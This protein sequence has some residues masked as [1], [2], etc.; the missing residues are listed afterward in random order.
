MPLALQMANG[1]EP[2]TPETLKEHVQRILNSPQLA[3]AETQ[4]RLLEYLWQHRAENLNEYAIATDALGRK[5]DFD[6]TVDASVRVHISRLRRKLKD[7]YL[8]TGESEVLVIPTG[9]H[10][11]VV[12]EVPVTVTADPIT[13]PQ[14]LG[15]L[16]APPS[17]LLLSSLVVLS[18]VCFLVAGFLGWFAG[19]RTLALS[20]PRP[21]A[22]WS[23]FLNYNSAPIKIILPTPVFFQFANDKDIRIRSTRVNDFHDASIDPVFG[24]LTRDLGTPALDQHYTVTADTLAA[25]GVARYLD[26]VGAR[27]RVSFDVMRDSDML[28]LEQSNVIALGTYQTLHPLHEYLEAMNFSLNHDEE[29]ALNAKPQSGEQKSYPVIPQSKEREVRPSIIAL[30]PGR[31][32]GLRVLLIESRETAAQ[33]SL[34]SSNA[35]AN[36]V[37]TM[38][39]SHGNP[40]Y[41]EMVVYTESNQG[42]ALRT[43]PVTMHA[44]PAHA[45]SSAM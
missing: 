26:S 34:L 38:L 5:A 24:S 1:K 22:F 15:A 12:L 29:A 2:S 16:A 9:T 17:F 8:E 19:H 10:Q 13:P 23:E 3:R 35:G 41:W 28:V 40:E 36:S 27:Q 42:H 31:S 39:R 33:I 20:T 11:L 45:P 6:S 7:Y 32:P 44:F 14:R 21:T 43:W 4:R 18:A 37:E 25:V 30:L